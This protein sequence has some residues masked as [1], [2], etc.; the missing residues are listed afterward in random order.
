[1]ALLMPV[2]SVMKGGI[3][4]PAFIRLWKRS[5]MRP[6]SSSTIATSVARPPPSGDMPVVSKSMTAI[7]P[8]VVAAW[9]GL[10]PS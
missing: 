5:R 2:S 9:P 1:M 10:R 6:W 3:H 7:G 4:A 8:M